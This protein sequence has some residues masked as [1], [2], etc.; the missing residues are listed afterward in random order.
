MA[1]SGP[2]AQGLSR[3]MAPGLGVP[4]KESGKGELQMR[5][6]FRATLPRRK[7]VNV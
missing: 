7:L 6:G 1:G 3:F 2:R 4:P 5:L